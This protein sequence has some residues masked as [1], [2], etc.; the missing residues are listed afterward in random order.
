M[1]RRGKRLGV[2]ILL[3]VFGICSIG[4]SASNPPVGAVEVAT[5]YIVSAG[6]ILVGLVLIVKRPSAKDA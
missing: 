3:I 1:A 4:N 2:G 6:A 5:Y